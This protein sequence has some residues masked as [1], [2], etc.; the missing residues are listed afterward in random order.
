MTPPEPFLADPAAGHGEEIGDA[1]VVDQ[2]PH[3]RNGAV[4]IAFHF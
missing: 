1:S 2:G 4:C 3:R